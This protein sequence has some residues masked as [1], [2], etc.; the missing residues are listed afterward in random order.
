MRRVYEL[1]VMDLITAD[2]ADIVT[3]VRPLAVV[4]LSRNRYFA[5]R[6]VGIHLVDLE[7][8]GRQMAK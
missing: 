5:A 8:K 6:H 2:V 4:A 3:G 7:E 1:A